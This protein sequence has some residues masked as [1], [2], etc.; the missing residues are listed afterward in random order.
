MARKELGAEP[1]KSL[2]ELVKSY[3]TNKLELDD[4]KKLCDKENAQIKSKMDEMKR[5]TFEVD[6]LTAK[7]TV[8]KTE[9]FNEEKLLDV[10]KKYHI[11][12]VR[13]R[14]YVDM[15][16]LES[17]I[18]TGEVPKDVLLEL[19]ACKEIKETK[20]LTITRKK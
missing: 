18:Y 9:S 14:E 13:T 12:C 15:D 17:E 6:D 3:Y 4:Y 20:A 16:A 10:V 5:E 8:R 7:I 19:N 11:N 1:E 2:D